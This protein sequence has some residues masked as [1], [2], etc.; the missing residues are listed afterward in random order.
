MSRPS[1]GMRVAASA[2]M[3]SAMPSQTMQL[4]MAS[5][6]CM[7]P[8]PSAAHFIPV[9]AVHPSSTPPTL[10][11]GPH[12]ATQQSADSTCTIVVAQQHHT[13]Q[14]ASLPLSNLSRPPA[15]D[16]TAPRTG[17]SQQPHQT[18]AAK[19]PARKKTTKTRKRAATTTAAAAVAAAA[20]AAPTAAASVPVVQ[21]GEG[22]AG[23]PV[24]R[25]RGPYKK[26]MKKEEEPKVPKGR[27]KKI[28]SLLPAVQAFRLQGMQ[29][30]AT[31][32]EQQAAVGGTGNL[33]GPSKRAR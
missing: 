6:S 31:A 33:Q 1:A 5:P 11:P 15:L 29:R 27:K 3:P 32:P 16:A 17:A 14:H 4:P 8:P 25:K 13:V 30:H 23:L 12:L 26:R 7:P 19:A 28:I 2:F 18:P 22:A 20:T 21:G 24:R 10:V 9:N